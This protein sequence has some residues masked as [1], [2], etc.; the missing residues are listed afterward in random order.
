M[1]DYRCHSFVRGC[2]F[3]S[4]VGRVPSQLGRGLIAVQMAGILKWHPVFQIREVAWCTDVKNGQPVVNDLSTSNLEATVNP[5]LSHN[6][7]ALLAMISTIY[8]PLASFSMPSST[9]MHRKKATL[10][11]THAGNCQVLNE[12]CGGGRETPL[13]EI[14]GEPTDIHWYPI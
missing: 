10:W 2:C 4:S 5:P 7:K 12:F 3:G 9:L 14:F 11:R 8:Q 13:H 1:V 6:C